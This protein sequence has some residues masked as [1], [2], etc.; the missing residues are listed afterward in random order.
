MYRKRDTDTE[1]SSRVNVHVNDKVNDLLDYLKI[2]PEYTV[3]QFAE[4]FILYNFYRLYKCFS[5][6]FHSL[7]GKSLI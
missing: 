6:I 7:C 4:H 3:T 1:A 5:E 2:Y